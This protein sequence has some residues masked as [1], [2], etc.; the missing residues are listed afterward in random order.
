MAKAKSIVGISAHTPTAVNARIIARTLLEELSSWDEYVS[1]PYATRELHD[2]RIAAKRFRYTLEIFAAILPP[3]CKGALAE[4]EQI[5]EELGSL[6]D[7]DVL[8]ALLRLC[9]GS[10][11]AGTGYVTL[12]AH[13]Q[14]KA[15]KGR[16]LINPDLLACFLDVHVAPSE[17]ERAGLEQLLAVLHAERDKQYTAFRQHWQQLK[18]RNFFRGILAILVD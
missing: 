3:A 8:I 7:S 11:D 16:L 13:A 17:R 14:K 2:L 15:V 9:L 18:D 10:W 12:L 6:H 4:V 5:Q 1:F